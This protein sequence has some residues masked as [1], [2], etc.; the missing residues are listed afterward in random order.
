MTHVEPQIQFIKKSLPKSFS[1]VASI[2]AVEDGL[3]NSATNW[4]FCSKLVK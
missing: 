3:N 1:A 4:C 2:Q